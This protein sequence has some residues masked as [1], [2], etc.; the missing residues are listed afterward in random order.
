[1]RDQLDKIGKE[2][3][4]QVNASQNL[5]AL[6]KIRI[7][8]LGKKG[9]LSAVLRGMGSVSAAERPKIGAA[10]NEWKQ[11]IESALESRRDAL[12]NQQLDQKIQNE[13][14]DVTRPGVQLHRGHLHPLTQTTRK[15]VRILEKLG[16]ELTT[17][18]EAETEYL[19]F[20]AINIDAHHPARDMHDTFFLGP[21]VVLR[22]HTSPI[23]MRA[24]QDHPWPLRFLCAG[25]T[26]RCD[27]DATHSPMFHQIEGLWID[28]GVRMSD[29]KGV[30][31]YLAKEL[32]GEDAEIR[33]RPSY[34]P[35]VEPGVEVDVRAKGLFGKEDWLEILGAGMVHPRLF[36]NA[37]YQDLDPD[38]RGFAFGIGIERVAM[39]LHRIGDIRHFYQG[40]LRFL[41]QFK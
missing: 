20:D 17:G 14:I 24:M 34:F 31:E 41:S 33:M 2:T 35:F 37:G 21:G 27:H 25:A 40:D 26:Y 23:Q 3:L 10:A 36:K 38:V 39:L 29:L 9:A 15:L 8:V 11:K 4:E 18:P 19:N 6:E 13:K 28:R 1:M 16:F 32:F 30:L 22:T 12:E 7:S 5:E